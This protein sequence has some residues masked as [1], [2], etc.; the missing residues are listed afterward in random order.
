MNVVG[1]RPRLS[2]LEDLAPLP[3]SRAARLRGL[4]PTT[5]LPQTSPTFLGRFL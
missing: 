4:P 1:S 5:F 2:A 3:V